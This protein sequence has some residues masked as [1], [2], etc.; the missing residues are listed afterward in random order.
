MWIII[1]IRQWVY[2]KPKE[3]GLRTWSVSFIEC[4]VDIWTTTK[5]SSLIENSHL[6]SSISCAY[7]T[8]YL[9]QSAFDYLV[10]WFN[11]VFCAL[12]GFLSGIKILIKNAIFSSFHW[13]W[14]QLWKTHLIVW[15]LGVF[16]T[17]MKWNGWV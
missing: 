7:S 4:F 16:C 1:I 6:P 2:T 12:L 9:L 10:S 8:R 17:V 13:I 11:H 5:S 15:E 3:R 14:I